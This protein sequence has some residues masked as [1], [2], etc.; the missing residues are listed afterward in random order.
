MI[1]DQFEEFDQ[2]VELVNRY[3]STYQIKVEI[4]KNGVWSQRPGLLSSMDS[5]QL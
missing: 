2:F 1:S 4:N 5:A 3:I